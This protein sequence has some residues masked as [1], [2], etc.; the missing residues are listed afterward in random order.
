M[1]HTKAHMKEDKKKRGKKSTMK[2][3]KKT[4]S[5]IS[6]VKKV[7]KQKGIKYGEALK[8]AS[9]SYKKK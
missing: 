9:K 4:G 7:A 5:W 2:K 3:T 8:V 1:P 6:H